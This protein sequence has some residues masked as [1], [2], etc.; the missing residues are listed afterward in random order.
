MSMVYIELN[1]EGGVRRMSESADEWLDGERHEDLEA[2]VRR[3]VGGE[4]RERKCG[5]DGRKVRV[6]PAREI[7]V[8]CIWWRTAQRNLSTLRFWKS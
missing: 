7:R 5:I 3:I 6:V 8:R 1:A 4:G 2:E